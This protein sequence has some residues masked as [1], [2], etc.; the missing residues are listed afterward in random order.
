MLFTRVVTAVVLLALLIAS[1]WAGRP[2]Y[3][4]SVL[5]IFG[6][7]AAWEWY[8]L[9]G[10]GRFQ[11]FIAGFVT[12][13]AAMAL[14]QFGGDKALLAI[15]VA[16]VIVWVAVVL[17]TLW[18]GILPPRKPDSQTALFGAIILIAALL[19]ANYAYLKYGVVFLVSLLAVVFIADIAAYFVGKSIGKRKLAPSIS[20]GKSWEG[21]IGGVVA[22]MIYGILCVVIDNPY[23]SK[24]FP[25]VLAD[26][27]GLPLA[28]FMLGVLAAA[29]VV[30]DL[31]ESML[32]RRAGVKDSGKVLPGHGG[33][34]DRLDA[35][36]PVLPLATLLIWGVG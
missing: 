32:K 20:P 28:V 30:G 7:V 14:Q 21:A 24:S 25:S 19:A 12:L 8:R 22:V 16:A 3:F 10:L 36:L 2:I 34:L 29:S 9:V 23:T 1:L 4:Q 27:W 6:V 26:A 31:F 35:Q 18:G 11:A 5:I 33:V 13:A 17:P 15:D